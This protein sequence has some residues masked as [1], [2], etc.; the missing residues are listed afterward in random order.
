M[1]PEHNEDGHSSRNKLAFSTRQKIGNR[2]GPFIPDLILRGM[3]NPW[4]NY[5]TL[6]TTMQ[7]IWRRR[8]L[9]ERQEQRLFQDIYGTFEVI[10]EQNILETRSNVW[11]RVAQCF[12]SFEW[13]ADWTLCWWML[14][15]RCTSILF[16]GRRYTS[17]GCIIINLIN[18]ASYLKKILLSFPPCFIS[19]L[20]FF[21]LEKISWRSL[22]YT[23]DINLIFYRF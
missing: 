16:T 13:A 15:Q 14:L 22:S 12:W 6:N 19:S 17:C 20:I 21:A 8:N 4:K 1:N 3:V 18:F 2:S 23:A 9:Q 10:G 7:K 5:L 11:W